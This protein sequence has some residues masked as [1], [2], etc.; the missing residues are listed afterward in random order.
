MKPAEQ[1]VLWADKL[2]DLS[3]LGLHFSDNIYD[4]AHYTT[5]Q[6]IAMAM[7]SLATET[8]L[9]E[10]EPL[11]A[12]VFSQP[13][14][15]S[16]GDAAVIDVE[17][18]ILLIRR[19]DNGLWAM[20]GGAL[21]VGETPAEGVVREA[22]EETGVR[23]EPVALVGVFDSRLCG[24]ISRHHVYQFVFLCRP[25]N[26]HAAEV[27]SYANEVLETGWFAEDALP[28]DLDPGHRV[29]IPHAFRVWRGGAVFFDR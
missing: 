6:D 27:P 13:T 29:R 17:G 16:V 20:P 28:A 4:R 26:G 25:L 1:L 21:E 22:L 10:M 7:L 19:A 14:P 12:P 15:L 18:Q 8:P 11:R 24:T 5:V 3:A 2:R 23:S 9:V